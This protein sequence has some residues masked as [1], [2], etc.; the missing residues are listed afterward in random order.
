LE[1]ADFVSLKRDSIVEKK[2]V[3]ILYFFSPSHLQVDIFPGMKVF[4][5]ER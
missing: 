4:D 1:K 2:K 3:K 5:R